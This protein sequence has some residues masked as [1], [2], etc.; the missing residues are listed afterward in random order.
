MQ[1]PEPEFVRALGRAY[2]LG[3]AAS[4][5]VLWLWLLAATG[6]VL[7]GYRRGATRVSMDLIAAAYVLLGYVGYLF[8]LDPI[9]LRFMNSVAIV[10]PF[11][12]HPW[13]VRIGTPTTS[14]VV[15]FVIL[16][17]ARRRI[18]SAVPECVAEVSPE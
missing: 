5:F 14:F 4:V 7:R 2:L 16:S 10:E 18:A 9:T 3:V 6:I 13:W 17:F 1:T 12:L 11:L 15:W 8:V